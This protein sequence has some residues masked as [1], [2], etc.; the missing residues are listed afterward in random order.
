MWPSA[1]TTSPLP[2]S[3]D[4]DSAA[5]GA[6]RSG[7]GENAEDIATITGVTMVSIIWSYIMVKPRTSP[8]RN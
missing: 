2:Y 6:L 7:N 5:N 3:T 1:L 4:F 8:S